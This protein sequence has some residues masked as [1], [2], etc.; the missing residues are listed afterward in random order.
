[1]LCRFLP[2]FSTRTRTCERHAKAASLASVLWSPAVG[3]ASFVR[4]FCRLNP[5]GLCTILRISPLGGLRLC[6]LW[7]LPTSSTSLRIARPFPCSNRSIGRAANAP[8]PTHAA[9]HHTTM[10]HAMLGLKDVQA[11]GVEEHSPCVA[12]PS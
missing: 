8:N 12:G 6:S 11:W 7:S 9:S 1:M 4:I 10:L 5:L 2:L 3:Q